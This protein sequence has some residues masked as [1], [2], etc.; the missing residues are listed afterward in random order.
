MDVALR[1]SNK[2]LTFWGILGRL[3]S[4]SIWEI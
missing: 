4:F 1:N 2:K 3:H